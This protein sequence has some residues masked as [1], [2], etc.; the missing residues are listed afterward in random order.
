MIAK[1]KIEKRNK[2]I[3]HNRNL[4]QSSLLFKEDKIFIVKESLDSNGNK[5]DNSDLNYPDYLI[6]KF[7]IIK[8]AQSHVISDII[9]SPNKLGFSRTETASFY[10][11]SKL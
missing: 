6:K 7:P 1:Q 4:N 10:T 11:N 9:D 8:N 5:T 3:F 2:L